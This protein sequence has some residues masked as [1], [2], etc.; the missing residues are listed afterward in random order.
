MKA[1]LFYKV[2]EPKDVLIL[3]DIPEP[4]PDP[5]EVVVRVLLAP[6]NPS[7]LHM[8]RGRYG[9]QPD[10]PASP[11][12]EG[13]GIVEALGAGVTEISVGT[14][15]ICIGCWN[16]WRQ[17]LV[18]KPEQLVAVPDEISDQTAAVSFTNP[19]TAWGLTIATH[20]LK[21]N[22]WLLQTAAASSVGEFVLQ[23]AKL[24]GF[25]TINV[26][27]KREQ[28]KKIRALSGDV[29]I[30][31]EDEDLQSRLVK[32]TDGKG[33]SK[34][35][36]CVAGEVGAE[37]IR[38]LAPGGMMLQYGAL[39]TH[40]QTDPQKLVMPVF[41][42]KLIYSTGTIRGWW[43]PRWIAS[44]SL[45]QVRNTVAELLSLIASGRLSVPETASYPLTHF[46]EALQATESSSRGTKLLINLTE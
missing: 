22:E 37:I 12:S 34:A 20:Q 17:L 24:H 28:E 42:P 41:S 5:D 8:I 44:Q 9:Y 36:D 23:L 11:G 25:K 26:I 32:V 31:T 7:D 16:L 29:V 30:C 6:I 38:N 13:V 19:I 2:G 14:R 10:L 43:L 1:L 21:Q 40:R 15:V 27:W 33:V 39:S 3:K 46:T 45:S 4:T 18:C 35:I